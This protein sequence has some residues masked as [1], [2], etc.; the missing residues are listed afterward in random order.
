DFLV[1]LCEDLEKRED[2]WVE[3]FTTVAAYDYLREELVVS[4]EKNKS[5]LAIKVSNFEAMKYGDLETLPITIKVPV[6]T[7]DIFLITDRPD[8][9]LRYFKM[10]YYF[11]FDL[12]KIKEFKIIKRDN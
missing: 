6:L 4:K 8:V 1:H 3:K 10:A 2:V 11:S 12:K 5:T 7:D 9:S